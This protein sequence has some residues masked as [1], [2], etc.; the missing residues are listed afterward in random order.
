MG[1]EKKPPA[2]K[3]LC[4][5]ESHSGLSLIRVGCA[6]SFQEK[7]RRRV[8]GALFAPTRPIGPQKRFAGVALL[9]ETGR[10][11][12]FGSCARTGESKGALYRP[13]MGGE[14]NGGYPPLR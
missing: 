5:L 11:R 2:A 3:G 7:G 12:N 14:I 4:P 8:L 13:G 1:G 10:T 6:G 9:P